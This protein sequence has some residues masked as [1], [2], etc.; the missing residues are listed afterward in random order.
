MV[1]LFV[2]GVSVKESYGR[3]KRADLPL[4]NVGQ[5]EG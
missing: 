1:R 2:C 5:K 3:P 4:N